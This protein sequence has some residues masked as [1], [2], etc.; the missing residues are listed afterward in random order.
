MGF[1]SVY[2]FLIGL[3]SFFNAQRYITLIIIGVLSTGYFGFADMGFLLGSFSLQH[4]DL[5]LLLIFV[6]LPFRTK[7]N[8]N[9]LKGIRNALVLFLLFL[10]VSILYDFILRGT[11]PMQIFR[12]TRKIGYLA[13]FFLI[14]SFSWQDY[15]RFIKAILLL[16]VIHA[17]LYISQYVIGYSFNPNDVVEN[18]LGGARYGNSQIYIIPV[19][20]ISFFTLTKIK[21]NFL[22]IILLIIAIVLTQTRGA[23]ISAASV[24]LLF[25]LLQN[26]IKLQTIII[27]SLLLIIGYNVTLNYF[28]IIG[29]RFLQLNKE[30]K[31]VRN[32]DYNNL[33][34]FYNQGSF[35]F[36]VGV[37][38]DRFMYVLKEPVRIILGA[39]FM[40]DMDIA[41]PIFTVGTHSP[42]LP[43]GFEQYNSVDIFFPNI[44][45]RYGIVGSTIY[46]Y[47]I[48]KLFIFSFKTRKMLWGKILFTYLWSMVVISFIN[49]T[50]YNG[51]YFI[52]IFI[53]IGLV[54][55]EK[56]KKIPDLI[57]TTH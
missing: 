49:E 27:L 21:T 29:E 41:K 47:F 46:L 15:Q 17:L 20:V 44:I 19:L 53:M 18:E 39:G 45:T 24:I 23:I 38:Y 1:I 9:Q 34:A 11:T 51:Q 56:K 55:R 4:G 5:A 43:S 54:L 30:I 2:L 36:R 8:E 7:F 52:F 32:M 28:P 25:L 16:T 31:M 48:Y 40:P 42:S 3:L 50:F 33:P 35:I 26:R 14:N 6:L 57:T 13:F 12:T 10:V 22:I 37:T